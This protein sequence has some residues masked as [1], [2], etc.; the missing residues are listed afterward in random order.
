VLASPV[1]AQSFR[2]SGLSK[3]DGNRCDE[4]VTDSQPPLPIELQ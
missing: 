2:L 4:R 3:Q 1:L